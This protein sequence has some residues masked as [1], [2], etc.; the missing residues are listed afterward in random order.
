VEDIAMIV[1]LPACGKDV[2]VQSLS[3]A[4][5]KRVGEMNS[6]ISVLLAGAKAA[7]ATEEE[8]TETAEELKVLLDKKESAVAVLYPALDFE[9]LPNRDVLTL[10]AVTM[11]YSLN[12]P[13]EEIKNWLRSGN[14]ETTRTE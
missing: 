7:G 5:A 6:K 4:N 3:R 14:G 8:R 2:E 9:E 11:D 12:V 13:E 1:T 10:I